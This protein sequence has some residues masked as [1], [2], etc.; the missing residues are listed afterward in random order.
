MEPEILEVE[1]GPRKPSLGGRPRS[2]APSSD[3]A[4]ADTLV[5]STGITIRKK[6]DNAGFVLRFEGDAMDAERM[7]GLMEEIRELLEKR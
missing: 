5:T 2:K 7:D 3:C 4:K 6:R 1:A